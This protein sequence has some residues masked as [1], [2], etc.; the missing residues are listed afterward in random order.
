MIRRLR[1][2]FILINMIS[3]AVILAVVLGIYYSTIF[4]RSCSIISEFLCRELERSTTNGGLG[5]DDPPDHFFTTIDKE[6][7]DNDK[8]APGTFLPCIIVRLD[9]SGNITDT[10][11]RELS[12]DDDTLSS[13]VSTAIKSKDTDG[14]GIVNDYDLRYLIGTN[15][16]GLSTIVF[17][18][19]SSELS[20]LRN[21]LIDCIVIFV[22]SM[23]LFFVL[24]FFLSKWATYPVEK[25]WRQQSQFIADASHELK[26][27]LTVILANLDIL[28][29]ASSS[30]VESQ[31]KWIS[32][33]KDEAEHMK[34]LIEDMLFLAKSDAQ[35]LPIIKENVDITDCIEST[36]LNFESIAFEHDITL[37][38]DISSDLSITGDTRQ[39]KQLVAI[40]I[41]NAC[42]YAG[43]GGVVDIAALKHGNDVLIK[44]HNTGDPIPSDDIGHIFERFYRA[45]KSRTRTVG[46]YGLGLSIAYGIAQSHGGKIN[47]TSN[48][49][50]GTTFEVIL[51]A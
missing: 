3:V 14:Y 44:I 35:S 45:D 21:Q 40:L 20:S 31:K 11:K 18:D 15:D 12:I 16:D 17:A 34:G 8:Y 42:K 29:D 6:P 49:S 25:A 36:S 28:E 50:A 1:T 47:V 23:G 24:S 33:S 5:I 22:I 43:K 27:P 46:G 9:S 41:D 39:I 10:T 7:R 30:T 13:I 4:N 38:S 32:N 2:K 48:A 26:T 19:V 37:N 51:P